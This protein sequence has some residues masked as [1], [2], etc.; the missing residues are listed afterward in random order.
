MRKFGWSVIVPVKGTPSAKSRFGGDASRRA[1]LAEAIALDTVAAVFATPVVELV[2][3]VTSA[4]AAPQ[5]EALGARVVVENGGGLNAAIALGLA[6]DLA[7]ARRSRAG[8]TEEY[9]SIHTAVLLGD[10][11]ALVPAELDAAFTAALA[12]N[13]AFVPD[14]SGS[15]TTLITA[16]RGSR[17]A[18]AFGAGSAELHR[19]AGY[20]HLEIHE[21]SGLRL[22][23][24][25]AE[26]LAALDP[27]R[28]GPLTKEAL[29]RI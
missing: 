28:L 21:A 23:V 24:D 26:E 4:A 22:D 11:P 13:R 27:S 10:L 25:T 6:A 18:P 1:A 9:Q 5:F 7:D 17:H 12:H 20:A 3:V 19:A 16:A 8:G 2:I 29:D 14:V 15:G